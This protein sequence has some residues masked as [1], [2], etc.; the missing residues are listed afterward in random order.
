MAV[1][2]GRSAAEAA[3]R[4]EV[5][6]KGDSVKRALL[7]FGGWQGHEPKQ[8]AELMARLLADGGL[9]VELSDTLECLNDAARLAEA[10]LIVPLWTMGALT[11]KQEANLVD[12]VRGG[13]GLA[14]FHGG[15]GDA[16][17]SATM[18]QWMVGGQFVAHPG[19]LIDFTVN[20]IDRDHEITRGLS[21]F[22]IQ[23][24]RYYMHVDPAIHVLATTVCSSSGAPWIN[25]TVM[26][27][28]WTK[29]WGAGRV[30]YSSV[31]HV[32]KDFDVPEAR[33]IQRR[34]MLWAVKN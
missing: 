18:F 11:E 16:F 32:L 6:F 4:Q 27:V 2:S 12:A 25:G 24:E 9:S 14:G 31:G 33:E 30:F 34:G 5:L 23:S 8:C 1:G 15:M 28:V 7:F 21:D 17:R 26:P 22:A 10:D 19:N 20:I 3:S 13:V 29:P